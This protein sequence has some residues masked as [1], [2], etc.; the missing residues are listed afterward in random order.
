VSTSLRAWLRSK[1][2]DHRALRRASRVAITVPVTLAILLSLPWVSTGA[3]MGAFASLSLLVFADFGGPLHQRFIAYMSTTAAGVPLIAIGAFAGQQR[4]AAV[5]A[6]A[7]V[8]MVV[9]L[10][11]VLRGLIAAAQSVLLL[12]MVLALTASTPAVVLPDLAAWLLGGLAASSAA[13]FLWPS[14]P[15]LPIPGLIADVL[16]AVAD[17]SDVRWVHNGTHEELLAARDRVNTSI[18]DLH[19]K[20]DGNLLRPS[21]VTNADRAL[22]ELVDEVSRLRYL[23]KWE[24]VADH[25]DPHV[26]QMTADL[27]GRISDALRACASR[28]RGGKDPLSSTALFEIRTENLDLTADWLAAHRGRKDPGYLREQIED[29][30]PVRITTLITS[31][32]T[33]QTIAVKPRPGDERADPPGLPNLAERLPTPLDR[34]RMHLS[35]DSPW[36]RSAVRS[37][38]ALSLSIAVA[39]SV[40]LQHPFWIVLGTLSALRFDALG[41]GRTAKQALIG[42]TVGVALSAVCIQ[43]FGGD[44]AI[45]WF[46]FPIALFWAAYTPGTLSFAVGQAGFSFVVIVMFSILSPVR[47][48]TAAA[49]LIDVVLGLAISL[50]V[51]LLMWPRGVVETLYTRLREAMQAACDYYVASADWMAGGAVNDRLLNDY[52]TQSERALDR[53]QEALDL[54]IAQ[55]PPQ[56]VA[57]QRWTALANTVHHVDFASRLMPQAAG[58]IRMRGDQKPLPN[59]LAGPLMAGA[60]NAREEL[61]AATDLWCDLQ[62]AFDDDSAAAS[63]DGT[64]PEFTTA[65]TVSDL[66]LA[67]DDYLAAPDDWHGSGSDPRPVV[68]TWLT[69]WAALFD[70]SAQVL[71]IPAQ[72]PGQ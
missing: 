36:F 59:Q 33:D 11:A 14:Q 30:F 13:V 67:I 3:L 71:R 37:A 72:T 16:D 65:P 5:V 70:R 62:P 9:G 32:I 15:N 6:M 68:A 21:G 39:K 29:T 31:R 56:A 10:L 2:P 18:A 50:V 45:W 58:I 60:N 43:L 4:W 46:L 61:M 51:S 24:D 49:R 47:L 57:L 66:R 12:S 54:S 26:A 69:D 23:Q 44:A 22:A 55:R 38:V 1:D 28:L 48:D 34:L 8:A 17:A 64:L 52:K 25:K 19:A 42:T 40:S 20:F 41:T 7:V 63:Y 53:A 27:C 35:W